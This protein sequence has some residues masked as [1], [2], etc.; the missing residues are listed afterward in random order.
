MIFSMINSK[1]LMTVLAWLKIKG[2]IKEK[3]VW[4]KIKGIIKEKYVILTRI[5]VRLHMEIAKEY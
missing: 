2:V 4:L 3:Y 1:S 5:N